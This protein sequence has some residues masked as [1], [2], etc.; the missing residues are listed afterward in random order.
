MGRSWAALALTAGA[1]FALM[2]YGLPA[3]A[4][5]R[6]SELLGF[7]PLAVLVS[8]A[9]TVLAAL[10]AVRGWV[11]ERRRERLLPRFVAAGPALSDRGRRLGG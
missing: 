7:R 10:P 5:P 3:R 8:L 1:V 4:G 6:S 2:L 11:A 9:T